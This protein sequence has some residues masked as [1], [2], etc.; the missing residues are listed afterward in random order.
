M[1]G[2]RIRAPCCFGDEYELVSGSVGSL[3]N[4]SD[5]VAVGSEVGFDFRA[6]AEPQ[7][8]IRND[9][10]I[11][12]GE[13]VRVPDRYEG[14][15]H[16]C[17]LPALLHRADTRNVAN[18]HTGIGCPTLP[19]AAL[20]TPGFEC[21]ITAAPQGMVDAGQRIGPVSAG[22]EDLRHVAGPSPR[23]GTCRGEICGVT[24]QPSDPDRCVLRPR[25][26]QRCSSRIDRHHRSAGVRQQN[27]ETSSSTTD[28]EH[29]PPHATLMT[30]L[31]E[32]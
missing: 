24:V 16:R 18:H 26:L 32:G 29:Q 20:G 14:K 11:V 1:A 10:N 22:E 27:G 5:S 17:D 7:R 31:P 13:G 21:E 25:D 12:R 4:L 3:P 9:D 6:L 2:S 19:G 30:T 23:V 28:V 15:I 8:R